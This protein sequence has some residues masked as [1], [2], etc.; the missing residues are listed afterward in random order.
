MKLQQL[1]CIVAMVRN[2]LNVSETA[3]AL[4]T[5]QPGVSK[6]IRQLE[7]EVGVQL[8]E[9]SG[10]QIVAVTPAGKDI[11]PV[12]ERILAGTEDIRN[13]GR[14]HAD[15]HSGELK[16]ATTHTQA[17][18]VLPAIIESFGNRYP[19]VNIHLHQ[20]TPQQMAAMVD[21]GEVDFVIATEGLH[22]Y[23]SLVMLPCSHWSRAVVVRPEHALFKVSQLGS[24]TLEALASYPLITYVFGFTGQSQLDKAFR[25]RGLLP[26]V[27]LTAADTDVIKTY[28]RSGLGVG[29]IARMAY[30]EAQD[31]DLRLLDASHLFQNS[32][33][34]IGMRQHR[35]L[36]PF[37]Y[38]FIQQFAPH[39]SADRVDAALKAS[40]SRERQKLFSD[41]RL[42]QY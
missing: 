28:V 42:P 30:E 24:L 36:R 3:A 34:H 16:L 12:A 23:D 31:A 40:S 19:R 39:L 7:D 35:E 1:R 5:S 15:P 13:L 11:I 20:G 18:Y 26:N 6:Q 29:I 37:M 25:A 17:R 38:D 33:T 2:N 4:H 10:R 14:Q 32:T 27:V 21:S 22:H 8:F 41:I 9:R